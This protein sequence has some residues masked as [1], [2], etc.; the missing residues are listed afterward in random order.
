MVKWLALQVSICTTTFSS[1][2]QPLPNSPAYPNTIHSSSVSEKA[3]KWEVNKAEDKETMLLMC[4]FFILTKNKEMKI[5]LTCP[6]D[7]LGMGTSET[8]SSTSGP[9]NDDT[10]IA[11]I[12]SK[13]ET[14][15]DLSIP[16]RRKQ[17]PPERRRTFSN[18]VQHFQNNRSSLRPRFGTFS[19]PGLWGHRLGLGFGDGFGTSF[20]I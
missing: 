7:K 11:F 19:A 10:R 2:I 18:S 17:T 20:F 15:R 1:T 6:I 4:Y 8:S 3:I 12:A 13:L 16:S 5:I 14:V 9:P